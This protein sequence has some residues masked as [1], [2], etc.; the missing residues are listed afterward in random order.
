MYVSYCL[1]RISNRRSQRMKR[2]PEKE[3]KMAEAKKIARSQGT[4][5]DEGSSKK[6]KTKSN[7]AIEDIALLENGLQ[8]KL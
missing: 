8:M 4:K 7:K 1:L 3:Q 2:I 5:E 6:Q